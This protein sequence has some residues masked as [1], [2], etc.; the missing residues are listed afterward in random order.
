MCDINSLDLHNKSKKSLAAYIVLMTR[1]NCL[2]MNTAVDT[3]K[4]NTRDYL[5]QPITNELIMRRLK[6]PAGKN[7]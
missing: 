1:S 4:Y 7:V 3:Q 5:F 6:W 2:P